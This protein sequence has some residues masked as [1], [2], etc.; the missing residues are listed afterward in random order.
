VGQFLARWATALFIPM[1]YLEFI[2]VLCFYGIIIA[3]TAVASRFA[4][5]PAEISEA[6]SKSEEMFRK[7]L[8][9]SPTTMITAIV[10]TVVELGFGVVGFIG[11]FFLWHFAPYI[12]AA[13]IFYKVFLSP[14][15][16]SSWFVEN[17]WQMM[18]YHIEFILDGVILMLVFFG[19]GKHLFF[20]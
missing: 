6:K 11:M 15:F 12:F 1:T 17:Q 20:N 2:A 9:S 13:A 8:R 4:V 14:C 16:D 5:V 19:P 7:K 18:L 3:L 10:S